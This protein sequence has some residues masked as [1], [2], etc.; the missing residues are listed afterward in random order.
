MTFFKYCL[1]K[2]NDFARI[3]KKNTLISQ[4]VFD[5]S[6]DRIRTNDTPGMK[7]PLAAWENCKNSLEKAH[8]SSAAGPEFSS[9]WES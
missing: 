7:R 2:S 5:G 8:R 4:G 6:G 9:G 1:K 3:T